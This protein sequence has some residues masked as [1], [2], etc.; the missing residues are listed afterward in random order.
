MATS[1]T[2]AQH[3]G[4]FLLS[5]MNGYGSRSLFTLISGQNLVAGTVLGKITAS[6]KVTILAPGAGD[7]SE[8][9]MGVLF[10]NVDATG[11]DHAG[12]V[13]IA[14][15]A[16][17]RDSSVSTAAPALGAGLLGVLTWPGGISGPQKTTATGQL[18]A[19]GISIR[20]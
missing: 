10:D 17:V 7:G 2:E 6:G 11:A 19:L 5:E 15:S 9:A 1:F 12:A 4:G 16:E 8:V 13:V 14:R 3:R 20:S 18:L